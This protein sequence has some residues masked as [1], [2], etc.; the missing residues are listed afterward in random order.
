M[1]QDLT[2]R[3]NRVLDRQDVIFDHLKDGTNGNLIENGDGLASSKGNDYSDEPIG[4][5]YSPP[6]DS[7]TYSHQDCGA[8][9]A[10]MQRHCGGCGQ[11]IE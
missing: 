5:S 6:A 10:M 11:E 4:I 1:Y 2:D 7:T 3:V 8:Q 9:L